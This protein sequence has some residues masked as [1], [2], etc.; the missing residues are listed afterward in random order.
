MPSLMDRVNECMS[1]QEMMV[2]KRFAESFVVGSDAGC[3]LGIDQREACLRI[4]RHLPRR[5]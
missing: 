4:C 3:R 1:H 5:L 2:Q